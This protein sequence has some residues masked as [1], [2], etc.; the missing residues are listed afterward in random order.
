MPQ[1]D[2]RESQMTDLFNLTQAEDRKRHEVDAYL[3]IDGLKLP[4]ELKST[5]KTSVSTVRDFGPDH[6]EKWRDGLH[7]IFAFY[8]KGRLQY[9]YYA[10]PLD[11]E[12]WISDHERYVAPDFYLAETVPSFVTSAMVIELLGG[13][14]VY[15][16]LDARRLMKNQWTAKE[17]ASNRDISHDPEFAETTAS[18][19]PKKN[20]GGYSLEKMTEILQLRCGY[21]IQRGSTLNNPKISGSYFADFE[22][23]TTDHAA[24][25]RRLVRTYLAKTDATDEATA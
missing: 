25:L 23:I 2:V 8:T 6:I 5:T 18:G 20:P 14:E 13:K 16:L 17:Y 12:S 10:S 21:V 1:D 22:K 15:S 11:M 9:C 24:T 19:K 4:F 7:W 3:E